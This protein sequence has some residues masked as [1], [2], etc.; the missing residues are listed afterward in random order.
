[1]IKI[2][3]RL[4]LLSLVLSPSMTMA[5]QELKIGV[6]NFPPFFVEEEHKGLFLEITEEIFKKLPEY[7]VKFIFMSNHRLLHE[8]NSGKRIDVACNI[9]SDSKVNAFLSTPIFRYTDVAVSKKT[10]KLEVKE[11]NDL[12]G[13]SI[14]AYQGAKD[15]LGNTFR[16][17]ALSNPEYSEHSHPKDT[18]YLMVS[19]NKD[20]RVGDIHI[21]LHDLANKRYEGEAQTNAADFTVHR[22]WSDVYSHIAFKDKELRDSVNKV[23]QELNADGTIDAIYTKYR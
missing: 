15:L 8:I 17:M 19:G 23:I 14:A 13:L 11:V 4:L 1:M 2:L 22:L 5:K 7:N 6:G 16:Q 18:T 10:A 20:I 9:F 12:A 21:F 3:Y